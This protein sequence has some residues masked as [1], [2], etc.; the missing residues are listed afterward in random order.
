MTIRA[1]LAVAA[2]ASQ[3]TASSPP[4]AAARPRAVRD[5]TFFVASDTHFGVPGIEE[6]NRRLI[7]ELNGLPGLDYPAPIVGRVGTPKGVL[8]TGDLTDYSTEDQWQAFERHYG[9][10]GRDGLLKFPVKEALGNHDFM[11][12]SPVVKHI[13]RRHGGIAYSFDW[14]DVHVACLGMYPSADRLRWLEQ[15]LRKVAAGR[16][17]VVFFHYGI[18]GPWSQSWESQEEREEL[19]RI[20]SGHRVAAIFHGH[21]HH[22]GAYRWRE[23]DV[24]RPGSPKHSS[25]EVMAVRIRGD[26]V[27]VAYRDFDRSAW[28]KTFVRTIPPLGGPRDARG[29]IPGPAGGS[30]DR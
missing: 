21:A 13:V 5:I 29:G 19:A 26:E 15:D 27:A 12:D 16:P 18:D 22:A 30:V 8:I 10:T 28:T 2:L 20:L 14:D 4:P 17:V 9:L 23:Y 25:R 6:R 11:G 1:L 24:F 7:E 3:P